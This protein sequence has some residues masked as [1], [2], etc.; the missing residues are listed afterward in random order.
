MKSAWIAIIA[1]YVFIGTANIPAA[2]IDWTIQLRN[3][4]PLNIGMSIAEV[5]RILQDEAA[6]LLSWED[7]VSDNCECA[8][9]ESA[10][11]PKN[12]GLMFQ[13]GY[14]VRFDVHEPGIQ[15]AGGAAVGDSEVRIMELYPGQIKVEPHDHISKSGRYLIYKP[16]DLNDHNYGMV[17]ETYNGVVTSFRAGTKA[18]IALADGC[19]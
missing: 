19:S 15:T 6:L 4:G 17:F 1:V 8:Y 9:L 2:E 13:N 10:K 11:K 7:P 5:R 18:A 12:L 16:T 3:A 14:L